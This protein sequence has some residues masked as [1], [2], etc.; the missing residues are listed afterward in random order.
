MISLLVESDDE[1]S[2]IILTDKMVQAITKQFVI[3]SPDGS[4]TVIAGGKISS[5]LV[6]SNDYEYTDGVYSNK[7]TVIGL[8]NT[9]F[10]SGPEGSFF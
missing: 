3:K 9:G 8:E 1:K 7:G 10:S 2:E 5:D 4:R 6:Q